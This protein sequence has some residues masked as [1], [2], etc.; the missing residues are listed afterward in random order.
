MIIPTLYLSLGV[1]SPLQPY[2]VFC[3]L[4]NYSIKIFFFLPVAGGI[5]LRGTA[6]IVK[7][8]GKV[9]QAIWMLFWSPDNK[10]HKLVE[11]CL[12]TGNAS[13][14]IL[15]QHRSDFVLPGIAHFL[16]CVLSVL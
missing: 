9:M 4:L 12:R 13:E 2:R 6:A 1:S 16:L 10:V 14:V 15:S 5:K 3:G 7:E 11:L 8:F